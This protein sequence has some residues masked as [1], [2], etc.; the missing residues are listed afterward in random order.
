MTFNDLVPN[1]LS[2]L[3]CFCDFSLHSGNSWN[4]LQGV[5]LIFILLIHSTL[6][7][8]GPL[9]PPFPERQPSPQLSSPNSEVTL[10]NSFIICVRHNSFT[11]NPFSLSTL[12]CFYYR[13]LEPFVPD[14]ADCELLQV[15]Y[16]ASSAQYCAKPGV[17]ATV[18]PGFC[19][20]SKSFSILIGLHIQHSATYFSLLFQQG[21]FLA[22]G[23]T[24]Q[25]ILTFLSR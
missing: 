4:V 16:H 24:T 8:Q 1:S 20:V 3:I 7:F 2:F 17:T 18:V 22:P 12:S 6:C 25:I 5:L 10:R 21:S 14:F 15:N 23:N 11:V 13:E 9:Q 19:S